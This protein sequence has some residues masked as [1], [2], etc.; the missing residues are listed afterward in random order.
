VQPYTEADIM[1]WAH[2]GQTLH[3]DFGTVYAGSPNGIPYNIVGNATPRRVVTY[4]PAYNYANESDPMPPEGLPIP[5]DVKIEGAGVVGADHHMILHDVDRR[6]LHELS[7]ADPTDSDFMIKQYSHWDLTSNALR[8]DEWTSADAAGLPVY[9][10]LVTYDEAASGEIKHALRFTLEHIWAYQWPARHMGYSGSDAGPFYGMRVRL[11][12]DVDITTYPGTDSPT[13]PINRAI[14]Q[15]MQTYG[16]FLAD[17]GENWFVSGAPDPR[18]DDGDLHLL[19][20]FNPGDC[21]EIVDTSSWMVD[22]D[23]A[24]AR[25]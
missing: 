24:E 15:C 21:F 17:A 23:S 6:E 16:M 8:P 5:A 14:L 10:L 20:Y 19:G 4:D 1:Y 25:P 2:S 22:I 13:S 3:M 7:I 9:P 12:S 11:R 18:W